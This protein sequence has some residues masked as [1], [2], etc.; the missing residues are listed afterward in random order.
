MM[1]DHGKLSS[2]RNLLVDALKLLLKPDVMGGSEFS[3]AR[4]RAS[5]AAQLLTELYAPV[6]GVYLCGPI[7]NRSDDDCCNWRE[8]VKSRL[9]RCLD[10]MDRDYRGREMEPGIAAEIVE[11]D[12]RDI[13]DCSALLVYYDRPSVGTSME[14]L[15]A[16]Q[17]GLKIVLIDRSGV[18]LSPWLLYHCSV[19]VKSIDEA[20]ALLA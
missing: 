5:S 6:G 14:I 18:P 20:V 7:N 10:P 2:V 15:F 16:F 11:N 12:K 17:R 9:P 13:L 19:V 3:A 8:E 1:E 4:D